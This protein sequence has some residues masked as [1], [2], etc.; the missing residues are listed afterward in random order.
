METGS[1]GLE[2]SG[3][4]F[5]TARRLL[6][7]EPI[8]IGRIHGLPYRTTALRFEFQSLKFDL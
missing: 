1:K 5:E 3:K 4:G 7:L 8:A 6:N 2:R